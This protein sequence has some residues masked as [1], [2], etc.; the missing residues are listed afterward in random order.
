MLEA[1]SNQEKIL[2]LKELLRDNASPSKP[3]R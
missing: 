2:K 3:Q 1:S